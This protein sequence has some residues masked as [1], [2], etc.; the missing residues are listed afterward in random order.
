MND[1]FLCKDIFHFLF[2]CFAKCI[3]F[4][5]RKS[6]INSKIHLWN[7]NTKINIKHLRKVGIKFSNL[8]QI[9]KWH[10][11]NL[12]F[13][14]IKDHT[15]FCNTKRPKRMYIKVLTA[16]M[17]KRVWFL[18]YTFMQSTFF[19]HWAYITYIRKNNKNLENIYVFK[20]S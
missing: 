7:S 10:I 12:L 16:V 5:R 13:Y 3:H 6:F 11:Q 9:E 17:S 8:T 18:F 19:L 4:Q 1:L 15:Q 14:W 2:S 20:E